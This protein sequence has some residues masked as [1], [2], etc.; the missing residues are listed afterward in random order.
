[1]KVSIYT[2]RMQVEEP[3]RMS[4][5]QDVDYLGCRPF[6]CRNTMKCTE[7]DFVVLESIYQNM[8]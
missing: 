1:M 4:T 5:I 6:R 8:I 2:K 3:F 7:I